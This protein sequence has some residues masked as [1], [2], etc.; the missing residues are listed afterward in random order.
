MRL[1]RRLVQSAEVA[2]YIFVAPAE[3]GILSPNRVERLGV[4]A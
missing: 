1:L 3:A 4:L 2:L